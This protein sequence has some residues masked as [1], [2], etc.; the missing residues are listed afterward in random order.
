[1]VD[2]IVEE[3]RKDLLDRSELGIKKYKTTLD[4]NELPLKDWLNHQ[5]EELLDAALYAKRA[6]KEIEK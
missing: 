5:Y 1:M 3:V 4:K 6:I 2:K